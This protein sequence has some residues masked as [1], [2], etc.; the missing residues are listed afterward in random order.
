MKKAKIIYWTATGLVA[1]G[2]LLSAIMY[3]SRN[4][5]IMNSFTAIGIPLYFVTMLGVAKLLGSIALI[6]PLWEKLKEWA[7]AGFAFVF[8]GAAYI[9]VATNTPAIAPIV[10][11]LLLGT[12]YYFRKRIL[13][14]QH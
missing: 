7:Y 6:S 5:M 4:E 10:F 2:M 12:S 13:E 1:A 8:I 11:L 9:H 3:L 14:E